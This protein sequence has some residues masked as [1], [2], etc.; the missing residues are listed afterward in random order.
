MAND[1]ITC[2]I[3]GHRGHLFEDFNIVEIDKYGYARLECK[4]CRAW[5]EFELIEHINTS[6]TYG[7]VSFWAD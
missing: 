2:G 7:W 3:C 6:D 1:I 5:L 4:H